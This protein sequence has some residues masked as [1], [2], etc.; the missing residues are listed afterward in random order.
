MSCPSTRTRPH[1]GRRRPTTTWIG[2]VCPAPFGP[3]RPNTSPAPTARESPSTAGRPSYRLNRF[4]MTRAGG[5]G[6][7][8]AGPRNGPWIKIA[9]GGPASPEGLPELLDRAGHHVEAPLRVVKE[10]LEPL[11]RHGALGGR[12]DQALLLEDPQ[13]VPD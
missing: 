13:G 1:S 7:A 11:R 3:T 12:L 10:L 8:I 6:V 2:V 4:S 9:R 5:A